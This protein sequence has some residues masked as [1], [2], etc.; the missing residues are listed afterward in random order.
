VAPQLRGGDGQPRSSLAT[1]AR[2]EDLV[3]PSPNAADEVR[4]LFDV[5]E[6]GKESPGPRSLSRAHAAFPMSP[7]SAALA[8]TSAGISPLLRSFLSV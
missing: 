1:P 8:M 2:R 5:L 7:I 6:G 4:A 3:L